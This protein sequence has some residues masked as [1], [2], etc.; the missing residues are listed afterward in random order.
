VESVDQR[1]S[2]KQNFMFEMKYF[3]YRQVASVQIWKEYMARL[4]THPYRTSK[5][6]PDDLPQQ[7][8]EHR[9]QYC[10]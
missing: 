10:L 2:G 3:D 7:R 1:V 6:C 5:V 9:Q 8:V 4:V